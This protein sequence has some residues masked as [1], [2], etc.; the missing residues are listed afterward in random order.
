MDPVVSV[1][2]DPAKVNLY[3]R[4]Y[5]YNGSLGRVPNSTD[6]I[7][8]SAWDA[9]IDTPRSI[10]KSGKSHGAAAEQPLSPQTDSDSTSS[11]RGPSN[12]RKKKK[13]S[14][15]DF[16]LDSDSSL[17]PQRHKKPRGARNAKSNA[18]KKNLSTPPPS[19]PAA[20]KAKPDKSP[21]VKPE[22]SDD[23]CLITILH[24]L[25][26]HPSA[27]PRGKACRFR[28]APNRAAIKADKLASELKVSA[29]RILTPEKK[30]KILA[31]LKSSPGSDTDAH[32][33]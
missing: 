23:Y 26:L 17:S 15:V 4:L 32:S 27:C 12:K 20:P 10:L 3:Y 2:Q 24:L 18:K 14:K 13:S 9:V 19:P 30:K 6:R 5:E 16:S 1:C 11:S 33:E 8:L 21:T 28:H 25:D 31:A 22:P 29:A 7:G